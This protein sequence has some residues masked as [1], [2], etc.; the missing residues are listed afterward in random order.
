LELFTGIPVSNQVVELFNSESEKEP[1]ATLNDESRP[2]GYYGI[3]DWQV[4]K[5]SPT[6]QA[7]RI[8]ANFHEVTDTNPATTF[9]GQ[10][11]DVS[12]VEK[13]EI[14]Q[15]E[16]AKRQGNPERLHINPY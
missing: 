10:L 6:R 12:Q 1:I 15:E 5:V 14:S 2:L 11:T 13:F 4:I 16:Y 7:T 9:T 8:R 3:R